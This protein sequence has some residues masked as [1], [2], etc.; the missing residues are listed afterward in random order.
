[1][2]RIIRQFL[3]TALLLAACSPGSAAPILTSTLSPTLTPMPPTAT[4][5]ATPEPAPT[6]TAEQRMYRI[7]SESASRGE[8]GIDPSKWTGEAKYYADI[9]KNFS[10]A[11]DQ[12][13]NELES[14]IR[15][16]W[17][18]DFDKLL[19]TPETAE[20][21]RSILLN[22]VANG[23]T[24]KATVEQITSNS[25]SDQQDFIK[26]LD[27]R[28][29]R[30]LQHIRVL[31][32]KEPILVSP[33]E[34]EADLTDENVLFHSEWAN[35][36]PIGNGWYG[37]WVNNG[38]MLAT[39]N[40]KQPNDLNQTKVTYDIP[41]YGKAIERTGALLGDGVAAD[42]FGYGP[43][44]GGGIA[45]YWVTR[46]TSGNL[47]FDVFQ[48]SLDSANPIVIP[49]GSLIIGSFGTN[50]NSWSVVQPTPKEERLTTMVGI[51]NDSDLTQLKEE[52][53]KQQSQWPPIA[54]QI[55]TSGIRYPNGTGSQY[56][57]EN[58]MPLIGSPLDGPK[59]GYILFSTPAHL[60]NPWVTVVNSQ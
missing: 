19:V 1:M 32:L 11:S 2:S 28:E 27:A 23:F 31:I 46:D 33:T 47:H 26:S 40:E 24:T 13:R 10:A 14:Y 56:F 53:L 20:V 5:T 44:P 49:P 16:R 17:S 54:S 48:V 18:V 34:H 51:D 9:F 8:P 35:Q 37:W 38:A 50:D 52:E 25:V 29:W 7:A 6:E 57:S 42:Y 12:E 39:M 59:S 3:L 43:M 58:G 4:S 41:L 15:S 60:Q 36:Q 21:G 22:F 45:T 55:E 30:F